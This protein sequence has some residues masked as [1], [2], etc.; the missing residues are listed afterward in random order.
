MIKTIL[1][2]RSERLENEF[3]KLGIDKMDIDISFD[4]HNTDITDTTGDMITRVSV[5][6]DDDIYNVFVKEIK[7]KDEENN[8]IEELIYRDIAKTIIECSEKNILTKKEMLFL[9][10]SNDV[11][12]FDYCHTDTVIKDLQSSTEIYNLIQCDYNKNWGIENT[13]L[14]IDEFEAKFKNWIFK[15][16][17]IKLMNSF[18]L[19]YKLLG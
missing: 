8:E 15:I 14:S 5:D 11:M 2:K 6:L 17:N 10:V 18:N 9:V 7:F 19:I 3:V 12:K 1:K 16:S 13:E 4:I